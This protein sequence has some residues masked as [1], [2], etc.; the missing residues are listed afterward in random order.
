MI[1]NYVTPTTKHREIWRRKPILRTIYGDYY[2]RILG[3][4]TKG[5]IVEIGSG[6]GNFKDYCPQAISTDIQAVNWI[7]L[8]LEAHQLPFGNQVI[9]NI[10]MIDTLH[11]LQVPVLFLTK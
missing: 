6:T 11:H 4:C 8:V 1:S 7:D 10:V 2:R 5:S 3:H 9:D